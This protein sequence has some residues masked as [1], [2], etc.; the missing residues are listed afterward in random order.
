MA[1]AAMLGGKWMSRFSTESL[2]EMRRGR[3][4]SLVSVS[5]LFTCKKFS[6]ALNKGNSIR[7]N[8]VVSGSGGVKISIRLNV[9]FVNSENVAPPYNSS[10]CG[11]A[12]FIQ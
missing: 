7:A 6:M 10:K 1:A 5:F 8:S 12:S 9:P 11:F 3:R 2:P 4:L